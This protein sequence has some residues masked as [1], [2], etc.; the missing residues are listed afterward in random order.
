[1]RELHCEMVDTCRADVTHVD[2]KG[3]VYCKAHG[4]DRKAYR[5]CRQLRPAEIRKLIN[6]ET[7][8][9]RAKRR[10]V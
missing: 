7:I 1:M 8:S 2:D 3:Y 5:P 10:G 9:Y 6:G 4:L